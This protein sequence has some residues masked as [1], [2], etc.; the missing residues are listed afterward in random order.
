MVVL[1]STDYIEEINRQK[2][3]YERAQYGLCTEAAGEEASGG[4]IG[5]L[6]RILAE[7][8]N[9]ISKAIGAIKNKIGYMCLSKEKKA[10]YDEFCQ[11]LRANPAAKNKKITVKDWNRISAEYDK[12][13][14]DIVN[15]YNDS[16]VDS[17]GLT[18]K[19]N[20]MF[21]NLNGVI[22]ASVGAI[23][24][25]AAM[26]FA[27]SSPKIATGVQIFLENNQALLKNIEEEIGE[28]NTAKVMN[29]INKLTKES[30][31][32][33]I[34]A[35][36][37]QHKERTLSE[38]VDGYVNSLLAI[39]A[40]P[41]KAAVQHSTAVKHMAQ[42]Y[43]KDPTVRKGAQQIKQGVNSAKELTNNA[44]AIAADPLGFAAQ[45]GIN[46]LIR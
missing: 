22:K 5:M 1:F 4:I 17:E 20:D 12:I 24:V 45:M 36:L 31:F 2:I 35:K 15:V 26:Y 27:K 46:R 13:E 6:K 38:T 29:K 40:N 34:M 28:K 10:Q 23:T 21:N 44:K 16:T 9:I 30:T 41:I 8:R 25:D 37:G 32:R 42:A 43:V 7:I 11:W 19:A 3:I 14:R 33:K 39:K 18:L